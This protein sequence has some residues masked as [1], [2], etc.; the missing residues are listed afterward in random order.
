LKDEERIPTNLRTLLILEI[1]GKSQTPMTATEINA[2]LGL[3]KQTVH[4]L[5]TTLEEEG[6]LTRV[7]HSRRYH[8]S[9]RLRNLGVGLLN[10]SQTHIVRHQILESVARE[11]RETVNFAA[12]EATGMSY[13]D[14]IETDWAFRIQ[15]PIG[16][17][18]PFH[19]TASGKCFLASLRG[20]QRKAMLSSLDLTA[21]TEHTHTDIQSLETELKS[22]EKLGY[23]TDKEEFM[24][25]MV[26]L[27]VPVLD[28]EGR[29]VAALAFHGP[30]QRLS[31]KSALE[32]KQVLLNAS[33]R[34]TEA[35]FS[36]EF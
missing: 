33:T 5:C 26:A 9:R 28:R 11:V 23:A 12:P 4:R 17:H 15:L 8:P 27:A 13:L 31:I 1:L 34:L 14:R 10:A 20:K 22:V 29:F 35:L 19:C 7:G 6:F 36:E 21:Q 16:S 25:G 30:T 18:V 32:Q 2:E 24:I 3:P